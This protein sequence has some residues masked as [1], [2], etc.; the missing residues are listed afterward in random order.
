VTITRDNLPFFT[1]SDPNPDPLAFDFDGQ[2]WVTADGRYSLNRFPAHIYDNPKAYWTICEV[3]Q[4]ED[5]TDAYL[6][7]ATRLRDILAMFARHLEGTEPP[8]EAWL[9]RER[10]RAWQPEED[11]E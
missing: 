3:A 4:D 7:E 2:V 11:E 9:E 5:D 10:R 6:F 8:S 1:S